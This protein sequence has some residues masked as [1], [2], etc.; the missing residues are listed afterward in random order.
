MSA[1]RTRFSLL[2]LVPLVAALAA[3]AGA[4]FSAASA[5]LLGSGGRLS[6]PLPE[7][8][9]FAPAARARDT[10]RARAPDAL[11]RHSVA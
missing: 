2:A 11:R 8:A 3:A 4:L 5:L 6:S 7:L 9:A 1:H 10:H